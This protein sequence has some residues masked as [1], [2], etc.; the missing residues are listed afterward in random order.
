MSLYLLQSILRSGFWDLGHE[1]F[2]S[3]AESF[4]ATFVAGDAFDPNFLKS[5]VPFYDA[6]QTGPP[7]LTSLTSLT[8]LQG[9]LSIIHASLFFHL[10]DEE[11]QLQVA[12]SLAGLLSP[13][14]GSII[15]GIHLG[16]ERKGRRPEN[17]PTTDGRLSGS[18]FCHSPESWQE[19]WDGQVFEKGT[20]KVEARLVSGSKGV[21][22]NTTEY[23]L[24]AWSVTRL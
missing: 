5:H 17:M 6:P 12:K 18:M 19:M 14:P 20:V 16:S 22:R 9:H 11:K 23:R 13:L 4:A 3:N 10:F 24:L 1:L 2:K 21:L 8:P 7:D 15:L